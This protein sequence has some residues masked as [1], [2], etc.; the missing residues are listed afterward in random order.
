MREIKESD[1]EILREVYPA[2]L[3]R[4]CEQILLEIG[5]IQSDNTESFHQRYTQIFKL[6]QSRD[7]EIAL[8]FDDIRR[9]NAVHQLVAMKARDLLTDD[10]FSRFSQETRERITALLEI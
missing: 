10:E 6:L 1:W 4:F 9:S 5:R 2:A 3:E 7:K 8:A